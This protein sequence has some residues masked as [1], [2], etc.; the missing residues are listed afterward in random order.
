AVE[1]DM[2]RIIGEGKHLNKKRLYGNF[3][4][5]LLIFSL[6]TIGLLGGFIV[7]I[8][9][10]GTL[11]NDGLILACPIIGLGLGVIIK[12]LVMY[13]K[14]RNAPATDILELMSDPYASPLRGKPVKLQ[15]NLIGRGQAGYKF[16]SDFK[17]QD[18]TG[19]LYLR[20]SSRF[21]PIGN[22]LFGMSRV[23]NLIG[24]Q[25][26]SQGWFRRGIMPW[27]DLVNL[28]TTDGTVVNSYHR[29]WSFLFGF[30]AIF[31]GLFLGLM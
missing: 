4:G 5:D 11:A 6:E 15:G 13:P 7:G 17:I 3:V 27:M 2:G 22:F 24:S 16:G 1:F 31:V 28:E 12:A 29:F 18:L 19:M 26:N 30:G 25:V 10:A 20:Y 8:L 21:G 14:Y 9:L 23:Q